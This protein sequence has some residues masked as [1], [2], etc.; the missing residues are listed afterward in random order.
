MIPHIIN[1]EGEDPICWL[2]IPNYKFKNSK[3]LHYDLSKGGQDPAFKY[4]TITTAQHPGYEEHFLLCYFD[5][6]G[7]WIT[8]MGFE[9]IDMAF[10]QIEYEYGL[11]RKKWERL[12]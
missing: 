6:S 1:L 5:Q 12:K 4:I 7:K 3:C 9:N 2:E 11:S 8:Q 10:N